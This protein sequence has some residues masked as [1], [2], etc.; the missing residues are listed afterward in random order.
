MN[1][2]VPGY[3]IEND[4]LE[5]EFEIL[6]PVETT[7]ILNPEKQEIAIRLQEID[8]QISA[9][10]EEIHKLEPEIER[11]TNHADGIDYIV[12][13]SSGIITG[14][15]DSMVVGE[16][17]FKSTIDADKYVA[18]KVKAKALKEKQNNTVKK[19]I[20]NARKKGKK[21]SKEEIETI[22]NNVQKKVFFGS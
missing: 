13:V 4:G 14:L 22:K 15:I 21:L 6:S 20:E 18:D 7:D 8:A 17:D 19:A 16:V 12:A 11:L 3:K 9:C 10:E 1:T 5:V 2:L